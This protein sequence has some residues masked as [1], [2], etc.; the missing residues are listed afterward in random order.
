MYEANE[1]YNDVKDKV[2]F[3]KDSEK[4]FEAIKDP[5]LLEQAKEMHQLFKSGQDN[6]IAPEA[7]NPILKSLDTE[8]ITA[9]N[10]M[11]ENKLEIKNQ[12]TVKEFVQT[13]KDTLEVATDQN[14]NYESLLKNVISN[15]QQQ[16]FEKSNDQ[17]NERG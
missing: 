10:M 16:Q 8:Q 9:A 1:K 7:I 17:G 3:V 13:M 6:N 2:E 12:S 14:L 15:M 5:K 11:I 4:I